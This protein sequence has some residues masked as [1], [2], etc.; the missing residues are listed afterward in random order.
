[1]EFKSNKKSLK[2]AKSPL[3]TLLKNA[4]GYFKTV[5]SQLSHQTGLKESLVNTMVTCDKTV[6]LFPTCHDIAKKILSR[7]FMI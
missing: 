6:S 3:I 4:E 7:F 5:E 2:Y 1:M